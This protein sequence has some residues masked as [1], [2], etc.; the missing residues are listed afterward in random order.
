MTQNEPKYPKMAQN[1]PLFGPLF[2]TGSGK[3]YLQIKAKMTKKE[4]QKHDQK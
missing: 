4:V 2:G 1:G 3:V